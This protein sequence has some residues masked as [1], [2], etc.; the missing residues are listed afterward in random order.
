MMPMVETSVAV[1]T[2]LTTAERIT[3][4]SPRLGSASTNSHAFC[5]QL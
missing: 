4:G 2:P 5:A 1:A 3:I